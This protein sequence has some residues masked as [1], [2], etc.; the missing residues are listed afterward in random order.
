[1]ASLVI[2]N[3]FDVQY[4]PYFENNPSPGLSVKASVTVRIGG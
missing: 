2:E 4:T 1:L 3:L